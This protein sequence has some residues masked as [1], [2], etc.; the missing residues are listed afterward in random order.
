MVFS[1]NA[2]CKD[3]IER[4]SETRHPSYLSANLGGKAKSI[5]ATIINVSNSGLGIRSAKPFNKGDTVDV[6]LTSKQRDRLKIKINVL[7]CRENNGE[8]FL[9][10]KIIGACEKH[11][12]LYNEILHSHRPSIIK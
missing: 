1:S 3:Q 4:R 6:F 5:F 7:A 2:E 8:Y 11:V 12:K 10:T 9:G